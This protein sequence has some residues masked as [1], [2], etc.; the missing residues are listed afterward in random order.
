MARAM[1]IS[2][3]GVRQCVRVHPRLRRELLEPRERRLRG[4]NACRELLAALVIARL[5]HV[6]PAQQGRQREAL[7]EQRDQYDGVGDGDDGVAARERVASGRHG[8]DRGVTL[9]L[10]A[11]RPSPR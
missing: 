5:T 1:T 2:I 4:V 3:A 9:I 11:T 8:G 10:A 6:E 7:T